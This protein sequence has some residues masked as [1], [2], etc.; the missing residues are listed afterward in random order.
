VAVNMDVDGKTFFVARYVN[1][2]RPSGCSGAVGLWFDP[3]VPDTDVYV[4]EKRN[5]FPPR[6]QL[7]AA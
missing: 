3:L 1:A 4:G 2:T 7:Q 5:A 6:R